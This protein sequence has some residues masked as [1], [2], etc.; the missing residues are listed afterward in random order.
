MQKKIDQDHCLLDPEAI[1]FP[2]KHTVMLFWFFFVY[3][4]I[5][6]FYYFCFLT[7]SFQQSW[8]YVNYPGGPDFK[9]PYS[10]QKV[11]L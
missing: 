11:H 1:C 10:Q 8:F 7:S 9:N 2:L 5:Y 4:F 6:C 3:L